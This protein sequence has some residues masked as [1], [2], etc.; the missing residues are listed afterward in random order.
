MAAKPT[1]RSAADFTAACTHC[2]L[3]LESC[4]TYVVTGLELESPRGR[5]ALVEDSIAHEDRSDALIEH[6]DSCLGCMG[7]VTACPEDVR[8]DQV[9][10]RARD[11]LPQ[12]RLRTLS[13]LV[14]DPTR[15]AS[16]PAVRERA[17]RLMQGSF[18][19]Y[20]PPQGV[21]R[22]RV[23][24]LAGCGEGMR[25]RGVNRAAIAVL[26][27]EGYE[28][29]VPPAARCCGALE[30]QRGNLQAAGQRASETIDAFAQIG[31][32]DAV[33]TTSA[34]CGLAMKR[35]GD[36]LQ[37]VTG[38]AFAASVTDICEFLAERGSQA[39]RGP[40]ALRAAYH[41]SCELAHGQGVRSQPRALLEAIPELE[42]VEVPTEAE[43]CCGATGAYAST[44]PELS[45]AL[46][47]RKAKHIGTARVE[48]VVS[49]SPTCAA[50]LSRH[51]R[52]L[53]SDVPVLHP[54]ELLWR[55]IH[56]AD[57]N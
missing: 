5:I 34:G 2:G 46:G 54:I 18:P 36:L 19:L 33:L 51:L 38:G 48:A 30:Q 45:A 7:C 6:I 13:E 31:Q 40:V 23:A 26:R 49:A 4:P 56:T 15:V 37:D 42:L 16:L 41:E 47:A 50:Q 24:L 29:V 57:G 27:A 9:L 14:S 11:A 25:S 39:T 3:C 12:G 22:G 10:M 43:I 8:F 35:F 32:V 53:R 21:S 55:S 17:G 20:T 1:L 28:V 52:S 44:H